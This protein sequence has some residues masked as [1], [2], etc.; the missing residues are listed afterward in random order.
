M[1]KLLTGILSTLALAVLMAVPAFAGTLVFDTAGGTFVAPSA[2]YTKPEDPVRAGHAF[3]GWVD[4]DGK[5]ITF[6]GSDVSGSKTAHAT[7]KVSTYQI[8]FPSKVKLTGSGLTYGS[9]INTYTNT[10][11]LSPLAKVSANAVISEFVNDRDPSV[12]ISANQQQT[13][14]V[15]EIGQQTG[16]KHYQQNISQQFTYPGN[17][18]ASA[19]YHVDYKEKVNV[20]ITCPQYPSAIASVTGD[21]TAWPGEEIHLQVA[22]AIG[23]DNSN[24]TKTSVENWSAQGNGKDFR[25]GLVDEISFKV[26]ENATGTIEIK[27]TV[28]AHIFH[29][30]VEHYLEK[31]NDA[32]QYDLQETTSHNVVAGSY[33][34]INDYGNIYEGFTIQNEDQ[35]LIDSDNTT[36]IVCHYKRN[37]HTFTLNSADGCST[38]GSSTNGNYRYGETIT[39]NANAN[40]GYSWSKWIIDENENTTK[41]TIFI[42]PDH[43]VTVTPEVIHNKYTITICPTEGCSAEGS[44]V[45]EYYYNDTVTLKAIINSGYSWQRW[46]QDGSSFSNKQRVTFRMPEGNMVL[47]PIASKV[48]YSITYNVNGGNELDSPK[49]SYTVTDSSY[50]LPTP[51]RGEG[52]VFLGWT[53]SNG[54]TPQSRVTIPSGTVGNLSYTANWNVI[55]NGPHAD[56]PCVN[57]EGIVSFLNAAKNTYGSVCFQGDGNGN[58]YA[59]KASFQDRADPNINNNDN[60]F[61]IY[62][63]SQDMGDTTDNFECAVHLGNIMN[64]I[65]YHTKNSPYGYDTN[66]GSSYKTNEHMVVIY[67]DINYVYICNNESIYGIT[68]VSGQNDN[69]RCAVFK[70]RTASFSY[71]GYEEVS[72]VNTHAVWW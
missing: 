56:D 61:L 12:R 47:T 65:L 15:P 11:G 29:Y 31:L 71:Y 67:D 62:D 36:I 38:A 20:S 46:D 39:L 23:Y 66:S 2:T 60:G 6:N 13:N 50:T 54:T 34:G 59:Q 68:N 19:T 35:T 24:Y 44:T 42:M 58:F 64:Y 1:K 52:F 55:Y 49:T 26:P 48:T 7:W 45:K 25:Y 33:V 37:Q 4:D 8:R 16:E 21:M 70:N 17:Y 3:T 22:Y 43:D 57:K 14:T 53:G 10:E 9:T 63:A 51:T 5:A 30:S 32:G 40:T 27:A 41:N 18:T 69:F 28:I 72:S